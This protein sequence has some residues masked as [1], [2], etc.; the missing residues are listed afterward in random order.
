MQPRDELLH[1][2]AD[3]APHLVAHR[4]L[5]AQDLGW[6]QL[7]LKSPDPFERGHQQLLPARRLL[8]EGLPELRRL[9]PKH[10]T[11]PDTDPGQPEADQEK[12]HHDGPSAPEAERTESIDH[13]PEQIREDD[14][15]DYRDEK[16]LQERRRLHDQINHAGDY[17][18]ERD[19]G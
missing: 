19:H 16:R 9:M 17:G 1:L 10:R 2:T 7:L 13:R 4:P 11:D 8:R 12:E 18:K 6:L 14:C 15:G 3:R 5:H